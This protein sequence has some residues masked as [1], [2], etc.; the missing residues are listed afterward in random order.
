MTKAY[1][2]YHR[3]GQTMRLN[4]AHPATLIIDRGWTV[5]YIYRG[6]NQHDRAPVE[7]VMKAVS[8]ITRVM[9][10]GESPTELPA[11]SAGATTSG[12]CMKKV[13]LLLHWLVLLAAFASAQTSLPT[14]TAL[15]MKL[16]TTLATLSATRRGIRSRLESPNRSW[17][18]A[19][20]LSRSGRPCRAASPRPANRDAFPANRRLRSFLRSLVLP[21]GERFMLNATLVDTRC[22]PR[23]RRQHGRTV[24]RRG[25]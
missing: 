5:R 23:H 9:A 21:N 3:I 16:E 8:E 13:T 20:P 25:T 12:G 6:D 7:E 1:G 19:K 14:G 11:R 4:I 22:P 17:W 2:L 15:K 10:V 24:Q 18:M